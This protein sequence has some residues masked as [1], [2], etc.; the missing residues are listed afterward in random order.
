[1]EEFLVLLACLEKKGCNE[2]ATRYYETHAELRDVVYQSEQVAKKYLP[3]LVTEYGAP[4]MYIASGASTTVKLV[5]PINFVG[6]VTSPG[7]QYK[8]EF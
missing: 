6:S 5:G 2:T 8:K 1:M 4:F 3:T 7:L